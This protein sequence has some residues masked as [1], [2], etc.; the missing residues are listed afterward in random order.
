MKEVSDIKLVEEMQSANDSIKQDAAW[1][2]L[3]LPYK[4]EHSCGTT[5]LDSFEVV[6]C[7]DGVLRTIHSDE[8]WPPERDNLKSGETITVVLTDSQGQQIT[9]HYAAED[10]EQGTAATSEPRT[11]SDGDVDPER[12]DFLWAQTNH[13]EATDAE[14]YRLAQAHYLLRWHDSLSAKGATT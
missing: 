1:K 14:K 6:L 4:I 9:Q 3:E 13:P 5:V 12:E 2:G 11:D 10:G 7:D 8:A